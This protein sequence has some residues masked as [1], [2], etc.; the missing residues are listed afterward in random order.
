MLQPGSVVLV[1]SII[2]T[3]APITITRV[4]PP[5]IA[6]AFRLRVP[7][8]LSKFVIFKNIS[9]VYIAYLITIGFFVVILK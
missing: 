4:M 7:L 2:P 9:K 5:P 8:I 1:A 6:F 3:V